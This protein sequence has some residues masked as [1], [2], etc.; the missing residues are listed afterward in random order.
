MLYYSFGRPSGRVRALERILVGT[1]F[2]ILFNLFVYE[3][4]TNYSPHFKG[5]LFSTLFTCAGFFGL[6]ES[7]KL[8][9]NEFNV[10][11]AISVL[12]VFLITV[13]LLTRDM[14]RLIYP[15]VPEAIGGGKPVKAKLFLNQDGVAFWKQTGASVDEKS[16]MS[17]GRIEILHQNEQE[18]VIEAPY[19]RDGKDDEKTII[20][21]KSLIDGILPDPE[22]QPPYPR[23]LRESE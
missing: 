17:S 22:K 2:A 20:I 12:P 10:V 23:W 18:L 14:S 5:L 6:V 4:L 7:Y 13:F 21:K 19:K 3:A 9:S 8:L 15:N 11:I 16:P 1:L